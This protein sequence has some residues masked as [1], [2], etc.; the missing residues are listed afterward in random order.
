MNLS[1]GVKDEQKTLSPD[2]LVTAT[3]VPMFMVE[4]LLDATIPTSPPPQ[5]AVKSTPLAAVQYTAW[6]CVRHIC[7]VCV[8]LS[9]SVSAW[10]LLS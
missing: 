6:V 9:V 5:P 2:E 8:C 3:E 10:N 1:W 4:K 7:F